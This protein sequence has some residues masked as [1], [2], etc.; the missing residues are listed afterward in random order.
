[1]PRTDTPTTT[2]RCVIYCRVS[3]SGQE[4]EGTSLDT[5][6]TRC[7]SHAQEQGYHVTGMFKDVYSGAKFR[8]RP[9]LS[10]LRQCVRDGTAD[11]VLAYA[12]DR[13]SRNQS[14]LAILSE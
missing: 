4:E 8:E 7:R 1:M 9:G 2:P 11:L 3:T 10:A 6:E 14:H 12:V 13:L 5:Q